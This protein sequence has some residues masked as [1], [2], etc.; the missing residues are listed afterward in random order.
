MTLRSAALLDAAPFPPSVITYTPSSWMLILFPQVSLAMHYR[1]SRKFAVKAV[2]RNNLERNRKSNSVWIEKAALT[3]LGDGHPGIVHLHHFFEDTWCYYFVLDWAP[4][5]ELQGLI[6][7]LGSLS[8][9]CSRY[10]AAQI[11]DAVSYMHSKGI[12]HRDLKPENILLDGENR[13]KITDFGTAVVQ[14]SE[15]EPDKFAGTAQYMAPEQIEKNESSRSSDIWS[16]GCVIYHMLAGRYPFSGFSVY[17][18]ME[19]VKDVNYVFPAG[20]DI[21]GRDLVERMLVHD[22]HRRL[23]GGDCSDEDLSMSA[24]RA[25]PF[26]DHVDWDTLW[27][28]PV[29]PLR[30]GLVKNDGHDKPRQITH[31]AFEGIPWA[32]DALDS[33]SESD[34]DSDDLLSPVHTPE[35]S[36]ESGS[37]AKTHGL[38]HSLK[39]LSINPVK[40]TSR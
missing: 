39:T 4:N 35:S 13:I 37:P 9:A 21:D 32:E 16:I 38:I 10:Y 30:P 19:K 3:R 31:D 25:H 6:A 8:P 7:H 14:H 18:V 15:L 24:L 27:T 33:S 29:P 17:L 5:G 34:T 28:D 1:T 26:F 2:D 22:P 11:I 23:G 12:I 36:P 20:F 40:F